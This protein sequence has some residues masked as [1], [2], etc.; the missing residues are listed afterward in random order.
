M[1]RRPSR[2]GEFAL[3]AE[4][5]APLARACPG[6][7]NLGD[8]AAVLDIPADHQLVVTKDVLAAGV[9]FLNDDPPDLIARKA[10]RVNL[11]D[12]AAM[13]ASP[14]VYFVGLALGPD[15]DD[16][17]LDRFAAGL[18]E[19][20]V[21]FGISLAGGDTTAGLGPTTISL[22]AMGTVPVN[23]AVR[24]RGAC[25]GDMIYV[26]GTLGDA[27]LW[28]A[29]QQGQLSISDD[30]ADILVTRYQL[31]Q[32]R[33]GLAPLL[34]GHI[35]A[36]IDVSDGLVADL[37]HI[38]E[39]SRVGAV[40]DAGAVPLSASARSVLGVNL[41]ALTTV[42]T[43][44]DDY[45]LLFT[46]SPAAEEAVRAAADSAGVPI[47]SIGQIVAGESVT[48]RGVDGRPLSFAKAGFQHF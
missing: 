10:L 1:A 15:V 22:T 28:I 2:R 9:H 11:S 23:G 35:S 6:A 33:C 43:G 4:V 21:T 38:C 25:A 19:D 26:T 40:V 48:V 8:D 7:L 45:E 47:T 12:L 24:R 34:R 32:P 14:M 42:L 3:I 5:F 30:T 44:G 16:P 29:A 39:Q 18:A 31:P 27:A 20:Q 36:M 13:G 37:G 46:A 41:D 17:W